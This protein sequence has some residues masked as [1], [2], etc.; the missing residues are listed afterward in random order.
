MGKWFKPTQED[1][2][3]I[4][5]LYNDGLGIVPIAKLYHSGQ[6]KIK[7][8][9]K[10]NNICL[11][12]KGSKSPYSFNYNFLDELDSSEKYYYIG[13]MY[14]D[15]Y[16]N[17][18]FNMC[19]LG[20]Q[21]QDKE[22]ILKLNEILE[23]N[24]PLRYRENFIE[25]ALTNE[26]FKNRLIELG[27]VPQKSKIIKFPE[28]IDLNNEFARDFIRGEYDGDGGIS[29]NKNKS[30]GYRGSVTFTATK[31]FNEK[32]KIF[33]EEKLGLQKINIRKAQK[34]DVTILSIN[35]LFEIVKFLDWLYY[36]DNGLHINR[37]YEKY[38]LLKESSKNNNGVTKGERHLYIKS[39]K[40]EIKRRYKEGES[41]IKIS[42]D[43]DIDKSIIYDIIKEES[44]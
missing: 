19:T 39:K 44:N 25:I 17:K 20:L 29:I 22:I 33:L 12:E 43:L 13:L 37:K 38:L 1:I 35:Y 24:R 10:E 14:S 18:D 40:E 30:G 32:L 31:Q 9:L 4:I 28:F 23:S 8:I 21:L 15:G 6:N 26:H 36:N 16:V 11:K 7:Q 5:K 2:N 42:K 27:C 41:G 3:N 34:S